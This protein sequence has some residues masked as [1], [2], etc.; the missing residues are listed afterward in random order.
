MALAIVEDVQTRLG[1]KLTE[2]EAELAGALIADA[3]AMLRARIPDLDQRV[4]ESETYAQLVRMVI[5]NAVVRVLKNPG[6]YRTE[7]DGDYS[8]AIDTRAAAG[9]LTFLDDELSQLG[10]R[11]AFNI[12]TV[13]A[14]G[15]FG[16]DRP[17]L[18]FQHGWP[19]TNPPHADWPDTI[20]EVR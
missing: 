19:V 10:A 12:D 7:T 9:F 14:A 4:A 16:R 8:Y 15:R 5:A 11:G 3:E 13:A 1:R 2:Q 17:D 18:W 20:R 6:G